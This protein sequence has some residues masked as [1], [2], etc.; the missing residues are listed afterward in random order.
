MNLLL[1]IIRA[2]EGCRLKAYRC[3]A[4]VLTIGWGATGK[5]VQAGSLWTQEQAD[6][7]LLWDAALF[8]SAAVKLAPVASENA[9]IA[10][11]DFAY[12]LGIT[13][14]KSSTMLRKLK[15]GD[16]VGAKK[17]LLKWVRGGGKVL[18]GL[19]ARRQAEANLF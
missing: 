3:P 6:A 10:C 17:E 2:F 19:V 11:A 16:T 1:N 5:D 15:R 8:H 4:G 14:L 18:P 13:R 9:Q 12:N 7:R